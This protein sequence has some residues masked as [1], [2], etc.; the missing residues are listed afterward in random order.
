MGSLRSKKHFKSICYDIS[1]TAADAFIAE[2]GKKLNL[3]IIKAK[4]EDELLRAD[5][6]CTATSSPSPLFDGNKVREG[7]H[8]NGIGSHSHH[9]T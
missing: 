6:I 3:E 4:T 9:C 2:M 8:I 7:I 5:I 1:D